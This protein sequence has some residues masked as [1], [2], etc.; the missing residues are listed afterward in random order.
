LL[1]AVPLGSGNRWERGQDIPDIVIHPFAAPSESL[2][3]HPL[4]S[5]PVST[6][7]YDFGHLLG[8]SAARS[9]SLA[10]SPVNVVDARIL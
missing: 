5:I 2:S 9:V 3:G 8:R 10:T 1:S 6:C 7:N 4:A